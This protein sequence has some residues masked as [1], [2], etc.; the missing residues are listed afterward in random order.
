[1][2]ISLVDSINP[3]IEIYKSQIQ[4]DVEVLTAKDSPTELSIPILLLAFRQVF[5]LQQMTT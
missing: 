4:S 2:P 1:M 5:L 3:V